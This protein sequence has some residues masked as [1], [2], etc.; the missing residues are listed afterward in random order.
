[1]IGEQ[2]GNFE[3]F[4]SSSAG[5]FMQQIRVGVDLKLGIDTRSAGQL[6]GRKLSY[7]QQYVRSFTSHQTGFEYVLPSRKTADTLVKGYWDLVYPVYPFLDCI[8]FEEA[9]QALWTGS[10]T[11]MNERVLVCTVNVLFAL[12]CL[13]SETLKP[14]E[15][16]ETGEMYFDR[17]QSLLEGFFWDSGSIELVSCFL[18]AGVY[19]QTAKTPR[20]CW[21]VI[22]HAIRM[23]QSLGLHLPETNADLQF[24]R[25]TEVTRRIWH[26]CILMD[27]VL[28]MTFGRPAM[29]SKWL[30]LGT[31]LPLAIDDEFL[32]SQKQE[33]SMRPDDRPCMMSFFVAQLQFYD[34][35][36]DILLELY[37]TNGKERQRSPDIVAVLQLDDAL[38][39]WNRNLPDHLQMSSDFSSREDAF[40][41]LAIINRVRFLHTRIL[42]FRPILA[43]FCLSQCNTNHQMTRWDE[44]LA[45][46]TVVQCCSLCLSAAHNMIELVYANLDLVTVTGPLPS[47]WYCVL[48]VYTAATVLIAERLQ[49]AIGAGVAGY[50]VAVSWKRSIEIL[51]AYA[52]IGESAK[53]CV[54][55]LEILSAKVTW[56]PGPSES[57]QEQASNFVPDHA[58]PVLG[59]PIDDTQPVLDFSSINFDLNDMFWL[60]SMPGNL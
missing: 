3:F 34:I 1:M 56:E 39:N 49:P 40:R 42:L 9:Y 8:S 4:G 45:Q 13:V 21:M 37:M 47:W 51:K 38:M 48:Y 46:R 30:S 15:R 55:A 17:A 16:E 59:I 7:F 57:R 29:I 24:P 5:S 20:R 44:S 28:S 14:E 23:A 50:S 60:N 25:R 6:T 43:Q 11:K 54:A 26:G 58:T 18:L 27:R 19:L 36:N 31:P 41:R 52:R 33:S 2:S 32:D 10:Q 22:G 53:R 12:G 35:I